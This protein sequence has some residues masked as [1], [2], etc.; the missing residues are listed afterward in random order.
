MAS[1][2]GMIR[3]L[4]YI[5]SFAGPGVNAYQQKVNAGQ[6]SMTAA[7]NSLMNY[8]G[9]R[10]DGSFSGARLAEMWTPTVVWSAVD[11]LASKTGVYKVAGR[12]IKNIIG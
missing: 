10:D 7:T 11:M 1:G 3:G 9:I 8:S 5:A 2:I 12:Q 4:M 6:D